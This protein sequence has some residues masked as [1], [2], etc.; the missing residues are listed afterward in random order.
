[1]TL[2]EFT[3][4]QEA[5]AEKHGNLIVGDDIG[6]SWR[7]CGCCGSSLGGDKHTAI[8]LK[9]IVGAERPPFMETAWEGVICADCV[10]FHANGDLPD[11]PG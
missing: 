2:K 6:F 4:A 1:M 7:G 9:P 8:T 3:A 11:L 10:L 5:F